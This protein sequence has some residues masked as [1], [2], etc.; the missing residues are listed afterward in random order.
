MGT[1]GGVVYLAKM[2]VGDCW[3]ALRWKQKGM[4]R[5]AAKRSQGFK[6][7]APSAGGIA[8]YRAYHPNIP[9]DGEDVICD[10]RGVL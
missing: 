9:C 8:E 2:V 10:G 4:N 6:K 1:G 5:I 7:G 3:K